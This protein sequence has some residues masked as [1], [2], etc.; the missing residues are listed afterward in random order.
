M[1]VE[2]RADTSIVLF[3]CFCYLELQQMN[4]VTKVSQAATITAY[5]NL[6]FLQIKPHYQFLIQ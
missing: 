2:R 3:N 6:L 5:I 1:Y 4:H